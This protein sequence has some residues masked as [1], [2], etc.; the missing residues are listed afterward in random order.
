MKEEDAVQCVMAVA[1]GRDSG[2]ADDDEAAG[3][4]VAAGTGEVTDSWKIDSLCPPPALLQPVKYP[5]LHIFVSYYWH[6]LLMHYV[7]NT[8][9]NNALIC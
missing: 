8:S 2:V 4:D 9:V 1:V 5:S 7:N 6:I 3:A